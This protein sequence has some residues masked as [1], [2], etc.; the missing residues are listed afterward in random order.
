LYAAKIPGSFDTKTIP[1]NGVFGEVSLLAG[2]PGNLMNAWQ[3]DTAWIQT[4]SLSHVTTGAA[5]DSKK[6]TVVHT[7]SCASSA[8][9]HQSAMAFAYTKQHDTD[10]YAEYNT[11]LLAFTKTTHE[12]RSRELG[13]V[14]LLYSRLP[15]Q[16]SRV[17]LQTMFYLYTGTNGHCNEHDI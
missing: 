7:S 3:T 12:D 16:F 14:K 11:R 4:G 13:V 17:K 9:L 6:D 8:F 15:P 5:P 2:L 10:T 1:S